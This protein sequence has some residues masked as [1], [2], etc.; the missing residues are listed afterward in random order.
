MITDYFLYT[1]PIIKSEKKPGNVEAPIPTK[2]I[3][4]DKRYDFDHSAVPED[5]DL[6]ILEVLPNKDTEDHKAIPFIY[7]IPD[8][9]EVPI[10][11]EPAERNSPDA[12]LV[13]P[14]T[15]ADS[16]ITDGLLPK[17]EKNPYSPI[18]EEKKNESEVD[19]VNGDTNIT[20]ETISLEG[21]QAK[22]DQFEEQEKKSDR[23][24]SLLLQIETLSK[25]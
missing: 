14:K 21:E 22:D 1:N 19:D 3:L 11:F 9:D 20:A 13:T 6:E 10:K 4:Q 23:E 5:D 7:I 2:D 25:G 17:I 24:N 15:K 16:Q 8:D 12:T 18:E